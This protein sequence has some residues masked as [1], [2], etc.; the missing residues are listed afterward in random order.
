MLVGQPE[1]A[2][3]D[4]HGL[5]RANVSVDLNRLPR[6]DVHELHALARI[7]GPD[8]DGRQ[9]EAAE[10]ATDLVEGV[11]VGGVATEPKLAALEIICRRGRL[12]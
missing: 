10:P 12:G 8:G 6:V 1:G 9:V 11:G 2:P 4:A 7:V 5:G 3:V